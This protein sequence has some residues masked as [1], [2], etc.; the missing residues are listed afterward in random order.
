[1]KHI[2]TLLFFVTLG[3]SFCL[4]QSEIPGQNAFESAFGTTVEFDLNKCCFAAYGWHSTSELKFDVENVQ[5]LKSENIAEEL[6][7]LGIE[8]G[9]T[10]QYFTTP[11]GTIVVVSTASNFE[12]VL[13]R[14]LINQ[15]ATKR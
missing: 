7:V 6:L 12:K 4:S 5:S 11:N 8:P 15:N 2:L 13:A 1:M 9:S 10:E 3:A 14:Y